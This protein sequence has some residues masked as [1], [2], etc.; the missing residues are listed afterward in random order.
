MCCV[1]QSRHG[2]F[3][4]LLL[5]STET[6]P[7]LHGS[8]STFYVIKLGLGWEG[9]ILL[10]HGNMMPKCIWEDQ[11]MIR[12]CWL[13]WQCCVSVIKCICDLK[14]VWDGASNGHLRQVTKQVNLHKTPQKNATLSSSETYGWRHWYDPVCVSWMDSGPTSLSSA[15][16]L[17]QFWNNKQVWFGLYCLSE[18]ENAV[19][20]GS[21]GS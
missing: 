6:Q 17:G 10:Q 13:W 18:S 8:G 14:M 16:M 4:L 15:L 3:C 12:Q 2:W 19:W 21:V 20:E 9:P 11:A 7:G 1:W 5:N